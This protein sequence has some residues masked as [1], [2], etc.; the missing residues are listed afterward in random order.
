[1]VYVISPHVYA[2]SPIETPNG[3]V[4]IGTLLETHTN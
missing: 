4:N 3:R 2:Y 1:M